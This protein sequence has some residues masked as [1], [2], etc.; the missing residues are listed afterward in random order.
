[1]QDQQFFVDIHAHPTLR[2]YNTYP[3]IGKRNIWKETTN[4][5]YNTKLG[6]WARMQTK[7]ISKVSQY[8]LSTAAEG[9]LRVIFDSLYP[10]EKGFLNF[11]KLPKTVF[12]KKGGEQVLCT[13]TGIDPRQLRRLRRKRS[14]FEELLDQY[15]FLATGQGKSPDG[16]HSYKL[17]SNFGEIQE[18]RK[19]D[20]NAIAVVV[21]IEGAHGFGIGDAFT[22]KMHR[23]DIRELLAENI[24]TVKSWEAPPLF[25]NLSHHF[26]NRL[27]GHA[28]SLKSPVSAMYNQRAG[29]GKGITEMGWY[30]L[31]Q[32]LSRRNGRRILVDIKHMSLKARMELYDFIEG[33]NRFNPHDKIPVICSHTGINGIETMADSKKNGNSKGKNG[34]HYH[35]WSINLSN[36][37]IRFI[38]STGG[39]IG[40]I[41][42]KGMLTSKKNLDRIKNMGTP[43]EKREAFVEMIVRNLFGAIEAIGDVSGWNTIAIGS[44]FDGLITHLDCYPDTSVFPDIQQDLIQYITEKEFRP[45]LWFGLEPRQMI[46]KVM[47]ENPMAFLAQHFWSNQQMDKGLVG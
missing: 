13:A 10:V 43:E 14:Y 23:K 19:T 5:D 21:T 45:D 17:V 47:A 24:K 36:E 28:R 32:M 38:H 11:R 34:E 2:A 31:E 9:G 25:V 41:L 15:A 18:L 40:L 4:P 37:E 33:Y 42:D 27:S 7:D 1:M 29:I 22:K 12:G 26:Y 20:P 8:N 30:V 16:N 6:R 46:R 3:E 44:D 39:M 35:N